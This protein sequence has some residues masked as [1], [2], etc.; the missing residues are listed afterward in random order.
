M[1]IEMYTEDLAFWV[2]QKLAD[3]YGADFHIR[4][5]KAR[6]LKLKEGK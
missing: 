5:C 1:Y 2:K 3:D 6:L 4:R